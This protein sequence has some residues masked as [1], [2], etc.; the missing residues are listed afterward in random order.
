M[1][2]QDAV[3]TGIRLNDLDPLEKNRFDK[4]LAEIAAGILADAVDTAPPGN[5][6]QRRAATKALRRQAVK[7][8]G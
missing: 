7:I 1:Q 2:S 3:Q 6:A 8:A 4:R 5:R